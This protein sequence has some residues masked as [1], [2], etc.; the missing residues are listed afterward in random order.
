MKRYTVQEGAVIKY[1]KSLMNLEDNNWP[2]QKFLTAVKMH[3]ESE[4]LGISYKKTRSYC[5]AAMRHVV[6]WR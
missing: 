5:E 1:K 3:P 4:E 6:H 2:V